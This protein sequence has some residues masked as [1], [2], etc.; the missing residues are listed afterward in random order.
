VLNGIAVGSLYAPKVEYSA[1]HYHNNLMIA[2]NETTGRKEPIGDLLLERHPSV[3]EPSK[4]PI[5]NHALLNG[6]IRF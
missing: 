3:T 4:N 2:Q 1:V 6:R 5:G